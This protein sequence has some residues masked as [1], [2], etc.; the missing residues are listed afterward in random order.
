MNL[1]WNG[2]FGLSL[3]LSACVLVL[4]ARG[5]QSNWAMAASAAA[6]TAGAFGAGTLLLGLVAAALFAASL[7]RV[8]R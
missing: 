7:W 1:L 2:L 4:K 3:I 5:R 8:L 6:L